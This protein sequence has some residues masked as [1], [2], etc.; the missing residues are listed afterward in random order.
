VRVADRAGEGIGGIG[1][2]NSRELQQSAHHVLDLRLF[3]AALAHDRLLDLARRVFVHR[4]AGEH[5]R[6]DGR[7]PR[8]AQKQRRIRIDVHEHLLD[9]DLGR[10]FLADDVCQIARDDAQPDRQAVA[11]CAD[12][13]AGH[14]GER[15]ALLDDEA[16]AGHAQAGIDAQD[17]ARGRGRGQRG[18][19]GFPGRGTQ[20]SSSTAD[21]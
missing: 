11:A 13:A 18:Q 4:Q 2:R 21:V 19:R 10:R 6:G 15:V 20:A 5:G 3:R 14:V 7:A 12:A 16:E 8:L 1:R 17:A 9:G